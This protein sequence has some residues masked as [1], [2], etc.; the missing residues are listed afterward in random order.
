VWKKTKI[1]ENYRKLTKICEYEKVNSMHH[2]AGVVARS[3]S[4]TTTAT[5]N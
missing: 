1:E 5:A 2:G 4:A 3:G